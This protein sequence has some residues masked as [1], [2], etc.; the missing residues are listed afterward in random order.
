[1][2]VDQDEAVLGLGDDIGLRDLAARDAERKAPRFRHRRVG[3]SARAI[4]GGAMN[5]GGDQNDLRRSCRGAGAD[6]PE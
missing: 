6:R 1:M 5:V 2:L 4:G 3:G